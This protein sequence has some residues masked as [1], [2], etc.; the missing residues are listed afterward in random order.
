M[1]ERK[2]AIRAILEKAGEGD[3]VLLAGKGAEPYQEIKGVREPFSDVD[4]TRRVLEE[5]GY[6]PSTVSE[7]N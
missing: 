1:P 4:E 7:E 2:K 6:S 5:M 3:V